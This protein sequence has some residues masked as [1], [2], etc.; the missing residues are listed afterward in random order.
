MTAPTTGLGLTRP[1]PRS[2]S[3]I[4][5]ARWM[6][7]LSVRCTK[8]SLGPA[9]RRAAAFAQ[10]VDRHLGSRPRV[11]ERIE[12]ERPVE[13]ELDRLCAAAV[14]ARVEDDVRAAL[15]RLVVGDRLRDLLRRR[16]GSPA[17]GRAADDVAPA[18][19][20]VAVD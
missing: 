5:R 9:V 2:A 8:K 20:L 17:L 18:L 6:W 11:R 15:E 7:S 13:V 16:V 12:V 4:A 19:L 14:R 10:P 1:M 3:S